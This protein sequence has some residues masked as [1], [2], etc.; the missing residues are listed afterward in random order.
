MSFGGVDLGAIT[1]AGSSAIGTLVTGGGVGGLV[2]AGRNLVGQVIPLPAF[3][4]RQRKIGTIIPD[5]IIEENHADRLQVTQHPVAQGSPIADHAFKL[6]KTLTM[7]A[8]WS[9]TGALPTKIVDI[10]KSLVA[11]QGTDTKPP[12]V[13][14]ISTGKRDY[15]NMVLTELTVRTSTETEHALIVEAQFTEVIRVAL[16]STTQPK[17]SDLENAPATAAPTDTPPA[18]AQPVPSPPAS[19][20]SI[21]GDRWGTRT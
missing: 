20:N 9:N 3:I 10:Y 19:P 2:S 13:I 18:Q 15:K 1:G 21:W 4:Q 8:G 5:V 12:E 17:T 7:R 11:L 14:T 16:R 6:P